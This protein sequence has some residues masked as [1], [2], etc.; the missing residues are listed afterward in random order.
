MEN[1]EDVLRQIEDLR[2]ELGADVVVQKEVGHFKYTGPKGDEARH[3]A[4]LNGRCEEY[5][6]WIVDVHE[7]KA[8]DTQRREFAKKQLQQVYDTSEWYSARYVAGGSLGIDAN[9]QLESWIE[10]LKNDLNSEKVVEGHYENQEV[11]VGGWHSSGGTLRYD[12]RN[13]WVDPTTEPDEERRLKAVQDLGE[14]LR[15]ATS[16][17]IKDILTQTYE[18][19]LI[20]VRK[21]A[22]KTLGYSDLKIWAHESPEGAFFAGL[23][24]LG[25]AA[26]LGYFIYQ[27]MLK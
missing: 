7:K 4:S 11:C 26:V 20:N 10:I 3:L 5:E 25:G 13:V 22:G 6:E 1:L 8:P 12:V 24:L 17:K 9:S 18:R 16:T 21:E 15:L 27:N 23:A 2:R 14:L 19:N